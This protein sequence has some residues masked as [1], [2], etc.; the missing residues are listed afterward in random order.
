MPRGIHY[1]AAVYTA[2]ANT[3]AAKSFACNLTIFQMIPLET[4]PGLRS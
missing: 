2:A 3:V 1:A 4:L